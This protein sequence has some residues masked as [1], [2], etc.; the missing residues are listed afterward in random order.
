MNHITVRAVARRGGAENLRNP[1]RMNRVTPLFLC[2]L[3]LVDAVGVHAQRTALI[4]STFPT[5]GEIR[6]P[7]RTLAPLPAG[8]AAIIAYSPD[9]RVLASAG[10]DQTIRVWDARTGEQ[11]TGELIR[12]FIGHVGPITAFAFSPDG[13]TLRSFSPTEG[14]KCWDTATGQVAASRLPPLDARIA[15]FKPG[16]DPLLAISGKTQVTLRNY[17]TGVDLKTFVAPHGEI[18]RLGFSTDGTKLAALSGQEAVAVW[19]TE[20]G[21]LI[22]EFAMADD[23]TAFAVSAT[24]LAAGHAEGTVQLWPL[25]YEVE[26]LALK[27]H[28]GVVAALA[29]SPK[30]E[31]LASA[32][33]DTTVKVWDTGTGALL[34]AQTGHRADVVSLAFNP[35]GQKM[36]SGDSTG[37]INY[38]TVPLPP[39]PEAD[40]ERIAA[41][42]PAQATR[43]SS[44][45]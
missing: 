32:G 35:N 30:G 8:T 2:A 33:A 40:R 19:E 12:T 1:H 4:T 21:K 18:A 22:R 41:A 38:W 25:D 9:G 13:K 15:A 36:A 44:K 23:V 5:P 39:L 45:G 3:S 31:P 29:F 37:N 20:T 24:H 42:V 6:R 27:Q 14:V 10:A 17:E 34:C 43:M 16:A 7:D 26:P 28:R 11:G